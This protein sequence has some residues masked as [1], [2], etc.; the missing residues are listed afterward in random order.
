MTEKG[1]IDFPLLKLKEVNLAT[2]IG[3][4]YI[5]KDLSFKLGKGERLVIMG[6]NGSGKTSLLKLINRLNT[7]TS[8]E[9]Y[10][11]NIPFKSIPIIQ[12]RTN[13]VLV[14]REPKL[15]GMN[16]KQTLAYPLVLQRLPK[17]QIQQRLQLWID[18]L[19]IPEDWLDY[20]ELELS[21]GQRQLVTIARA[22]I[23]QPKLLLLDEATSSLDIGNS[24]NLI[25]NLINLSIYN[26][27]GIIMV[28]HQ[29]DLVQQFATRVIYLE[30]GK[31]IQDKSNLNNIYWNNLRKK[32]KNTKSLTE[33][34][35]FE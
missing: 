35:D 14:P 13:I 25:E 18:K 22:L 27:L 30:D 28:N 9:L 17:T 10:L 33:E 26:N 1:D 12:L 8:G 5:L 11:E 24:T 3:S 16:V 2:T 29:L 23:M 20:Q 7:P 34:D 19:Q 4:S 31:I 32:I 21:L 6:A 15:L